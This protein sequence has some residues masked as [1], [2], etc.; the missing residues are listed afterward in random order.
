[1]FAKSYEHYHTF[2]VAL[3]TIIL[4]MPR[5]KVLHMKE[6]ISRSVNGVDN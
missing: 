2:R 3:I 4:Y 5:H 1:M 6:N